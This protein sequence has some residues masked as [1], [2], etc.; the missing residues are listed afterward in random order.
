MSVAPCEHSLSILHAQHHRVWRRPPRP[1]LGSFHS[2][3]PLVEISFV[4]VPAARG[5]D[6]LE[7][8]KHPCPAPLPLVQASLSPAQAPIRLITQEP[9]RPSPTGTKSHPPLRNTLYRVRSTPTPPPHTHLPEHWNPVSTGIQS[10]CSQ[11]PYL[12][13]SRLPCGCLWP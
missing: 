7:L 5:L 8:C 12:S 9:L 4:S 1:V 11:R 13:E 2:L 10:I 3:L 6:H